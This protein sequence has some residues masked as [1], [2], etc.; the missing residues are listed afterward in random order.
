M[1]F[2]MC[3]CNEELRKERARQDMIDPMPLPVMVDM[4]QTNGLGMPMVGR[5]MVNGQES[6]RR[7]AP[8]K[9][10]TDFKEERPAPTLPPPDQG[11]APGSDVRQNGDSTV[12]GK[13]VDELPETES[14]EA[15]RL[16][17]RVE[18]WAS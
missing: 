15:W 7:D 13:A 14:G 9:E 5:P 18:H 10:D 11:S 3:C 12:H 16:N 4:I 17:P 1:N 8:M 6:S 2:L